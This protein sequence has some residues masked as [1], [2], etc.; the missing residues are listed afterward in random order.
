[1]YGVWCSEIGEVG[2]GGGERDRGRWRGWEGKRCG[3]RER[4]A[5]GVGED[6]RG[7]GRVGL[8]VCEGEAEG[9]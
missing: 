8:G 2:R 6:G 7:G 4:E 5:G 3:G 1:M 9:V